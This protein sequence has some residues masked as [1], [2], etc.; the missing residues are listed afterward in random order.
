[1]AIPSHLKQILSDS[2]ISDFRYFESVD[3]TNQA[4]LAWLQDGAPD[5]SLVFADHQS[6]G[7]GRLNRAWVTNPGSAIAASIILCPTPAEQTHASLFSP[8]AG[9]AL[10][11]LL[12]ETYHLPAEIK[13]PNDVLI[14]EAKIAGIL[15]EADWQAGRLTGIVVGVGINITQQALPSGISL[16]YPATYLENYL[17]YSIDR[18]QFLA[19][20]LQS[21]FQW[22]DLMWTPSFFNCWK[23]LLAFQ[24]K[25]VYI[26]GND[27]SILCSGIIHGISPD[28]DLQ[29]RTEHQEIETFNAGDVHLR[30]HR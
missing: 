24:D 15:T 25:T 7:K 14:E 4:A 19:Q 23:N 2:G 12:R 11:H 20:F 8:L 30:Q 9:I 3:S 22:R 5:R 10:A 29:I 26:K 13:W 17:P 16:E 21:L 6:R 1:M 28:G 18:Y 27:G